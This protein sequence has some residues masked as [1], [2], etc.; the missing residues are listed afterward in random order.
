MKSTGRFEAKRMRSGARGSW[1]ARVG[2]ALSA[3]LATFG[4]LLAMAGVAG[5][6]G[7]YDAFAE[8]NANHPLAATLA[9]VGLALLYIGVRLWRLSRLRM[10]RNRELNLSPHLMKRHD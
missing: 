6:L 5:L 3:V 4:V 10:R 2:A 1:G 7:N 9:V 8:L